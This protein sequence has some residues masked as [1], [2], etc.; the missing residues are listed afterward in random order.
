METT[1][2]QVSA[3]V[4][5]PAES[6]TAPDQ[7][8]AQSPANDAG[9]G[10]PAEGQDPSK[11]R[12]P[13]RLQQRIDQITRERYEEQRGRE[14]A[15][16]KLANFE[17]Q[18]AHATRFAQLD[19]QAPQVD[20]F[21]DLHSYQMALSNW[22]TQR[23]AAVAAA[24]WDQRMQEQATHQAQ[25]ARQAMEQQQRA[26]Y[27]NV[28]LETKMSQGAKLYPDF[29]QTLTNPDLPSVRGTPLFDAV[30]QADNAPHIAYALAKNPAELDR[31]LSLRDP[32]MIAREVFRLD[33]KFSGNATT[34]APP[35]P[36][37]RNG[38]SAGSTPLSEIKDTGEWMKRREAEIKARSQR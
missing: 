6:T 24:Q 1:T 22:T 35:P 30:L 3:P 19:A 32:L 14:A 38:S 27:E 34:S 36:P 20:Q 21:Q 18:Q 23:A 8:N 13:S 26:A 2:E 37:S 4:A 10:Q 29:V 9:E 7:S 15:E 25:Y 16:A 17:R 12:A 28:T 33:N 5:S 11:P 31:L